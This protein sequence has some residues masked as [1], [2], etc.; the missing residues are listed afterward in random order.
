MII[1]ASKLFLILSKRDITVLL[2]L[3]SN[4]PVGSSA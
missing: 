4:E 2:D 1:V 3:E